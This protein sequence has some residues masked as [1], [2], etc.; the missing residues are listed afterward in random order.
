[1]ALL[2]IDE[3]Q[4][5]AILDTQLRRLAALERQKIID[6]LAELERIIADLEDILASEVRQRQII[7]DG[8]P[9][10]W[11]SSATTGAARSSPRTAT[12]RWRT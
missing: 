9:P 11:R 1:M 2:E 8:S 7:S 10:S 3:L 4:A 5:R 6:R 12:S